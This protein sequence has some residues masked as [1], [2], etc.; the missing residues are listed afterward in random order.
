MVPSMEPVILEEDTTAEGDTGKRRHLKQLSANVMD[1]TEENDGSDDDNNNKD[2]ED[3]NEEEEEPKQQAQ[4]QELSSTPELPDGWVMG[5]EYAK[6]L[7][8]KMTEEHRREL[9]QLVKGSKFN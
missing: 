5:P 3:N 4:V 2:E 1:N 8:Q 9:V 6:K 7:N